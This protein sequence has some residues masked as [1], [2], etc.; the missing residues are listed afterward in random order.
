LAD[1][2]PASLEDPKPENPSK[3]AVGDEGFIKFGAL[4]QFW[5]FMSSVEDETTTTFRLRRAEMKVSGDIIPK[6]ISYKIVI[7]PAAVLE[8]RST[9]VPVEGQDPEPT[10]AGTVTVSQPTGKTSLLND[11]VISYKSEYTDLSL[12]QFKNGVSYEGYNSSSELIFPERSPVAKEF[13]DKR[14]IGLS[15]SKEFD[16]FNYFLAVL[17]GAGANLRDN[18]NQK[19]LALRVEVLP[20]DGLLVGLVGYTSLGERDEPTTQ[21]I[22]E[23]DLR[24]DMANVLVQAEFIRGNRGPSDTAVTGQGFYG[25]LGYT[26]LDTIQPVVRIGQLDTDLDSD[27]T[28]GD[29]EL[30]HFDFGVN[31]FI[32]NKQ[33][34]LAASAS[35]FDF[36]QEATQTDVILMAQ[37]S[38]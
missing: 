15:L 25:A 38:F 12:G 31:Y 1:T 9:A 29:D 13:G 33:A 6:T 17:N 30:T 37:A 36:E 10:E 23:A 24:L 21:D 11:F 5:G 26:F 3:L 35:I 19:D 18:N 2:L 16:Y 14:D 4:L 7:D 27:D 34:K 32:L 20:V 28:G 22:F 8:S